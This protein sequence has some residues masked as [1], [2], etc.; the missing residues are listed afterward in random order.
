MKKFLIVCL[1]IFLNFIYLFIKLFPMR[2]NRVVM[3]SRQANSITLDFRLIKEKLLRDN[4]KMEV[5]VLTRR[6]DNMKKNFINYGLFT[7]KQMYYIAT[8]RVCVVDSYCIPVSVLKHKKKLS[9]IQ[10]WHSLGAIKEFGYQT[11]GKVSGREKTMSLAMNMHKNYDAIISGSAA[12]TVHFAKAFNYDEKY[13]LNYGLPR[14]DYL[15][16]EK[17]NLRKKIYKEYPKLKKKPVVMYAPT[18]R[19]DKKNNL[20]KLIKAFNFDKYNLILKSHPN[21]KIDT[22]LDKVYKCP[23][24]SALDLISVCD[25]VITDYSAIAIE[26]AVLDVK[27]LYYVYDYEKYKSDNGLNIDLFEDMP[28]CV[29]RDSKDLVKYLEKGNYN[30]KALEEYKKKY[31]PEKLGKST[32]LIAKWIMDRCGD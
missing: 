14:I 5:I 3:I 19:T 9:I 11:L 25:Y 2:K 8:S 18:F 15:L 23:E 6:F 1:K 20:V 12:M 13:F 7:L 32:E 21:Q 29:F 10:I 28:G 24:F 17:D 16:K 30:N 4:P 27:L 31:L 22:N 26:A